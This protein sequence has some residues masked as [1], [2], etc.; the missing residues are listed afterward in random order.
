LTP[1]EPPA[2][3]SS[4]AR[5]TQEHIAAVAAEPDAKTRASPPEPLSRLE[6]EV[7]EEGLVSNEVRTASNADR[8]GLDE[9]EYSWPYFPLKLNGMR[10]ERT[11]SVFAYAILLEGRCHAQA[12][13]NGPGRR[14]GL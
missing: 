9:R 5:A 13:Y 8:V 2:P 12:G 14:I 6:T 11:Y 1:S 4:A 3:P 10:R 7:D